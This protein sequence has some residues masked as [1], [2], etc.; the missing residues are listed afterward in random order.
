MI[1][2]TVILVSHWI[3][4]YAEPVMASSLKENGG[5]TEGKHFTESPVETALDGAQRGSLLEN[6]QHNAHPPVTAWYSDHSSERLG[7]T[8]GTSISDQQNTSPIQTQ[9]FKTC[10]CQLV[11]TD[12][13]NILGNSDQIAGYMDP[14]SDTDKGSDIEFHEHSQGDV[15]SDVTTTDKAQ[16]MEW[17][18]SKEALHVQCHSTQ[19]DRKQHPVED[20]YQEMS[21]RLYN[22][23]EVIISQATSLELPTGLCEME[24]EVKQLTWTNNS[25]RH[26]HY[27]AAGSNLTVCFPLLTSLMLTHNLGLSV[28]SNLPLLAKLPSHLQD[29]TLSFN[30]V[31]VIP[32][33]TFSA[34]KSLLK[35][36]LSHNTLP[37]IHVHSFANFTALKY[38]DLSFNGLK[39][40]HSQHELD[41]FWQHIVWLDLHHNSFEQMPTFLKL[42]PL[43]MTRR[44]KF[45]PDWELLYLDLSHN[46]IEHLE[47]GLFAHAVNLQHLDLSYNLLHS[48]PPGV[49]TQTLSNLIHLQL[50]HN[51]ITH[52]SARALEGLSKLQM[53]NF[54]HNQLTGIQGAEFTGGLTP[55]MPDAGG[56]VIFNY[57][58]SWGDLQVL[59]LSHNNISNIAREAFQVIQVHLLQ[60]HFS[61]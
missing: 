59:D 51:H 55:N 61:L 8:D 7:T 22:V 19:S 34:S 57:T 20:L 6:Q 52:L 21:D 12:N 47:A 1:Y 39:Y 42:S 24:A 40:V 15:E 41:S 30:N 2:I 31:S 11:E 32:P 48:I 43:H 46:K 29:L 14:V 49:F 25:L 26:L 35:L 16:W 10:L 9:C 27:K 44:A 4:M 23:S 50:S 3:F 60:N 56:N 36:D 28:L 18:Q 38:L 54:S 33:T 58:S 13:G 17:Q 45:S 5:A 53:L 37:S